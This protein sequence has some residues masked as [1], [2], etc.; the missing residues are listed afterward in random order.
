MNKRLFIPGRGTARR[1]SPPQGSISLRKFLRNVIFGK[2]KTLFASN[3][4][5][6]IA[7]YLTCPKYKPPHDL[8][9][10]RNHEDF[11]AHT[12]CE[13]FVVYFFIP[14]SSMWTESAQR[15]ADISRERA[16]R[17][18][19]AESG[20]DI[21]IACGNRRKVCFKI[22]RFKAEE[23]KHCKVYHHI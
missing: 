17:T 9:R 18:D 4:F 23:K 10:L 15:A 7:E 12:G 8:V 1:Q 11:G 22:K 19:S 21:V 16:H 5:Y 13:G 6:T 20:T 2:R 14:F 3:M